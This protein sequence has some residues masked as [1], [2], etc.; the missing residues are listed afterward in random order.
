MS[1]SQNQPPQDRVYLSPPDVG[2]AE[3]ARVR[4][5]FDENWIAPVGPHIDAFEQEISEALG[6]G[7]HAAALSSGTAALHLALHLS[8][9]GAGDEVLCSTFTFVAA[10]NA[11]TYA[12][13]SP[14]FVDSDE[15]T[16]NMDPRLLAQAL[17]E[18]ACAGRPPK[19]VILVH[20]YGQS[21]DLNPI[22]HACR[23]HGVPLIEDAA[24]A[25]GS[26][27][28]GKAVGTFGDFGVYSFN[29]NKIITTSSGGMLVAKDAEVMEKARFLASQARDPA[30]H[31]E[32]SQL[33]FNYRMSNVLA[34]IGRAQLASLED[35]VARRRAIFDRY[36]AALE[37]LPGIA[38][39]PDTGKDVPNRWLTCITLDPATT[40]TT[41]E[42]LRLALEAVNVE[43]R[44]LWKPMHL[45]PLFSGA[46]CYGGA[47][48]ERLFRTGLCLPSGSGLTEPQ[49][50]RVVE[51]LHAHW[52]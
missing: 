16:W 17:R 28:A 52:K 10:A 22:V 29:G 37:R 49:F 26:T 31:Y 47:V 50:N 41:P 25:L 15:A 38:C 48:S 6:G 24:E 14:I 9:V 30:P 44:P 27:Y 51:T 3:L 43:S 35:K 45:Q 19:A 32:H 40:G 12:G 13:A 33:G 8:G 42:H 39:I 11:I 5:A 46:E 7:V 21:A 2:E 20:L 23:E 18:R 34:G 1:D 36:K 4:E